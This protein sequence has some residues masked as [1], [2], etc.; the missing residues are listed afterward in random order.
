MLRTLV[1]LRGGAEARRLDEA[2]CDPEAAQRAL[3]AELL[4]RNRDTAFGR[5]HGF[6]LVA[7][8]NAR[9]FRRQV[10]VRDFEGFRPYVAR[11]ERGERAVLTAEAPSLFTVTSGTAGAPKHIPVTAHAQRLAGGL[12][13]QWMYR[14]LRDHPRYLDGAQV[15]LVS[16]AIEGRTPG[17]IAFGSASGAIYRRA[18][19]VARRHYAIP[20]EVA[21]IADYDLRY[22]VT[23]RFA[24]PARVTTIATAN[25]RTLL[26]LAET[27][28]ANAEA[29]VRAVHD[30][31]LGVDLPGQEAL[32][33]ALGRRLRPDP[34]RA[35]AL[36]AIVTREG[37]L[38]PAACWPDLALVSCWLGGSVGADAARL[39]PHYGAATPL[40][41]LGYLASEARMTVPDRD[42]T[43]A[44]ILALGT[45]YYE[46]VPEEEIE[47]PAPDVRG[48]HELEVGRRYYVLITTA[49]GLYRYDLNDVVEVTGFHGRAP[50]IAFLRKGRDMA[51]LV[52]EKL[53]ANHVLAALA[54]LRARHAL[55]I[56][57][58]RAA[59]DPEATRY[60][61]LLELAGDVPAARLQGEIL[62]AFDRA[63][64]RVNCEY[65]QKRASRRLG[66]PRILVMPRGWAEAECR[67]HVAAGRR[68]TQWKWQVLLAAPRAEDRAAA[69][70]TIDAI[71]A[72]A[73]APVVA[74]G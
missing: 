25:P 41:D 58:A 62:P 49:G 61:L 27:A 69:R 60:E 36:A 43:P 48:A 47:S 39:A 16:P 22:F 24:L 70:A 34:A 67:R 26:R 68:D 51:S 9:A 7:N 14:T 73:S 45:N 64:A 74:H 30:G 31:T 6:G 4:R 71:P 57:Q 46:F 54:E 53:H 40:R 52:G 33:A 56:E 15:A 5:E 65:E 28:T 38:R 44:G 18:P 59:A 20:Y 66:A 19:F 29:L 1:R 12:F 55:P 13:R 17:G 37:A 2:A 8:G 21:E 35:A 23:A 3:L 11:L 72:S 32:G 42:G 10:P 63:L 50:V